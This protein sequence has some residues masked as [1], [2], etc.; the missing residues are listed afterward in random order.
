[1]TRAPLAVTWDLGQTLAE[2]DPLFLKAK[3]AEQGLSVEVETIESAV[4]EGW[5]Q[6]SSAVR[7]GASGHPWKTFMR[8][9][10]THASVPEARMEELLEFLWTDQPHRNLWRR[11]VKGMVEVLRALQAAGIPQGIVSNSEGRVAELAEELGWAN[12]FNAIADSG[13]LGIEK[14]HPSIFEWCAERLGVA[15]KHIIHIGDVFPVDVEGA[16]ASGMRAI[17][18]RGRKGFDPRPDVVACDT[19]EE[20]LEAL[21]QW[22][23]PIR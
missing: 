11:P 23:V 8:V 6:Y 16:L 15:P 7:K 5:I 2:L 19:A 3:L 12:F 9:I 21:I 20:V 14:P 13:K 1:M 17:W 22:G 4:S 18:F 10:L